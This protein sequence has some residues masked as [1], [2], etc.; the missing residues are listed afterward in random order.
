MRIQSSCK[1][2]PC[3]NFFCGTEWALDDNE[4][5]GWK[6]NQWCAALHC[7]AQGEQSYLFGKLDSDCS[8]Y[9]EPVRTGHAEFPIGWNAK[10]LQWSYKNSLT[11]WYFQYPRR[12]YQKQR[13]TE[14]L[15]LHFSYLYCS[16]L[17]TEKTKRSEALIS[18]IF[19]GYFALSKENLET[20][21]AW[22]SRNGILYYFWHWLGKH[23]NPRILRL[24]APDYRTLFIGHGSY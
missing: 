12:A 22:A 1:T 10:L 11:C 15:K 18:R 13:I 8:R 5:P 2:Q 21:V 7:R 17:K 4:S 3:W 20:S 9:E 24:S 14:L 16:V 23:D 19:S 6:R